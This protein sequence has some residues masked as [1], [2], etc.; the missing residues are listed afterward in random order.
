M[1]KIIQLIDVLLYYVDQMLREVFV[2]SEEE[3]WID[4]PGVPFKVAIGWNRYVIKKTR[5]VGEWV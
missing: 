1:D 3:I 5:E 4:F 2:C